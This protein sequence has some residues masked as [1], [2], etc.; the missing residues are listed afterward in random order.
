MSLNCLYQQCQC[1][2]TLD[3]GS[4]TCIQ[5]MVVVVHAARNLLALTFLTTEFLY[6][7]P[8]PPT[9]TIP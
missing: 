5:S 7:L 9:L 1:P 3:R 2:N 4:P 6:S 8:R